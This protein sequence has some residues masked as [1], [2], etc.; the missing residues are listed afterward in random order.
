MEL[1]TFYP[2]TTLRVT[3]SLGVVEDNYGLNNDNGLASIV[4]STAF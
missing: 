1:K 4:H 3:V 2:S